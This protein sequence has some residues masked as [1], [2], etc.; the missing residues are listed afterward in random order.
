MDP[1][2]KELI[3]L[4]FRSIW[5]LFA[6][7]LVWRYLPTVGNYVGEKTLG[8]V[9]DSIV[10]FW[11]IQGSAISIL[12][13]QQTAI[14]NRHE[15]VHAAVVEGHDQIMRHLLPLAD[16]VDGQAIRIDLIANTLGEKC[17]LPECPIVIALRSI[18]AKG[19]V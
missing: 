16:S 12:A 7:A 11:T 4:A 5:S 3:E 1:E 17:A 2:I 8:R 14:V 19:K 15:T 9:R 18:Q 6:M 10:R 13:Q